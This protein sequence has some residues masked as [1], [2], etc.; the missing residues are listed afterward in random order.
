[1]TNRN[2]LLGRSKPSEK[3]TREEISALDTV[4]VPPVPPAKPP[5][6]KGG[7]QQRMVRRDLLKFRWS[8]ECPG[9]GFKVNGDGQPQPGQRLARCGRCK[10]TLVLKAATKTSWLRAEGYLNGLRQNAEDTEVILYAP[11]GM[12]RAVGYN[13]FMPSHMTPAATFSSDLTRPTLEVFRALNTKWRTSVKMMIHRAQDL[14]IIDKDESRQLYINYNRRGWNTF[15]PFDEA[16]PFEEP[17]LVKR[18]FE[19]LIERSQLAAALPFKREDVERLANLLG[20][21]LAEPDEQSDVWQFIE[22]LTAE[23]PE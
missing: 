10:L 21:Y 22:D 17:R 12:A 1:M 8:L 7:G 15:E 5:G 19:A 18:V 2:V 14:N 16:E 3:L 13:P 9:C 20:G 11:A 6:K 23:F 4:T